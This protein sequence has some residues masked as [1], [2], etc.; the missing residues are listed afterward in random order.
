[1][2]DH[3]ETEPEMQKKTASQTGN[4][5]ILEKV[6]K[7]IGQQVISEAVHEINSPAKIPM[8]QQRMM[9][10]RVNYSAS[11][12]HAFKINSKQFKILKLT[13]LINKDYDQRK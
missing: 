1:M 8:H 9:S 10:E 5:I 4:K 3:Q 13:K 6:L 2:E 12:D 7:T 11:D